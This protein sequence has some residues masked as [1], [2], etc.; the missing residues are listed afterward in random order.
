MRLKTKQSVESSV[1]QPGRGGRSG[2]AQAVSLRESAGFTLVEVVIAAAIVGL[3][4]GG[5]IN[6]YIQAGKRI[7][8]TGYSLA[9][10]SLATEVVEQAKAGVWDPAQQPPENDLTNMNLQD[11]SYNTSTKTYTGHNIATLDIPY[12]STNAVTATNYVT[13]QMLFVAGNSNVPTQFIRVDTVWPFGMESSHT[14]FTNTICT[15]VAPD[16]RSNGT[17]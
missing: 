1:R 8:W 11:V 15:M 13:I 2:R 12:K 5:V 17:F 16:N 7:E 14:Y 6:S 10:Q 3:I 4:F 9:A